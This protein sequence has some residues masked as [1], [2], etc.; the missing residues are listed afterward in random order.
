[1]V[2]A[3]SYGINKKG[4]GSETFTK[5]IG[6]SADR[7]AYVKF[8]EAIVEI[9]LVHDFV[10]RKIDWYVWLVDG[11]LHE[12]LSLKS[13]K[14]IFDSNEDV[15]AG[16]RYNAHTASSNDVSLN[17]TLTRSEDIFKN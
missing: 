17:V 15:Y 13:E 8:L 10:V 2:K 16:P 5:S 1:M 12:S 14:D 6:K 9:T 4:N 11:R 7:I 3:A